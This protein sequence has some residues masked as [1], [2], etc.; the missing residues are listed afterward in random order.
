M[1]VASARQQPTQ[2]GFPAEEPFAKT[3]KYLQHKFLLARYLTK[4]AVSFLPCLEGGG[5]R[6]QG[7]RAFPKAGF[8][9]TPLRRWLAQRNLRGSEKRTFRLLNHL[10]TA[11]LKCFNGPLVCM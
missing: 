6:E 4:W 3:N 10:S 8:S 9:E 7:W 11:V 5:G 2:L 1:V